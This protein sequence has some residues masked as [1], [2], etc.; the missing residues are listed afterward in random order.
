MSRPRR[1][2]AGGLTTGDRTQPQ[3]A[4]GRPAPGGADLRWLGLLLCL[5]SAAVMVL[6]VVL[7][8]G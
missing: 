1:P 2:A 6:L 4:T 5:V 3:P 7:L 8:V